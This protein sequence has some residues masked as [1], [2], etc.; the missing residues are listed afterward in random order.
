VPVLKKLFR[1]KVL[2]AIKVAAHSGELSSTHLP[3]LSRLYRKS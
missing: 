1:G 2:A 3:A